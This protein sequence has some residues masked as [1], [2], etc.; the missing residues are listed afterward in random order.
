MARPP[1]RPRTEQELVL[2]E[3][4]TR[5]LWSPSPLGGRLAVVRLEP[6]SV[7]FHAL[8]IVVD[9]DQRVLRGGGV[10]WNRLPDPH[11]VRWVERIRRQGGA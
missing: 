1:I 6:G 9:E 10:R 3:R 2:G 11:G 7:L 8:R 5:H 4:D